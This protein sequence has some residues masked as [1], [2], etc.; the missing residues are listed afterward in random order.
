MVRLLIPA[1]LAVAGVSALLAVLRDGRPGAS[2]LTGDPRAGAGIQDARPAS[3]QRQAVRWTLT[4][5]GLI[6]LVTATLLVLAILVKGVWEL[7]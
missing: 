7:F 3:P 5:L 2:L 1:L 4:V 6:V